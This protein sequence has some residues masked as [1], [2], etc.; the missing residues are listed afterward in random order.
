M[1]RIL[2]RNPIN[3]AIA[4]SIPAE[5]E[6]ALGESVFESYK[7]GRNLVEDPGILSSLEAITGPLLSTIPDKRYKFH[8]YIID[9]PTINAFALPG[10]FVVL[11]TGLLLAAESGEEVLGVLAH[12]ISHVTL[13]HGIRKLLDSLGLILIVKAVLG[14]H[15][16]I[17]GE[18]VS[19]G[20]F[21]LNQNFSRG[22]L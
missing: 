13:Q 22:K 4:K 3:K 21:L 17:W 2:L 14:D 8:V 19:N 12:E 9:D 11:N 20:A 15:S 6:T 16:G 10:G 5:W 1:L 18:V 7:E